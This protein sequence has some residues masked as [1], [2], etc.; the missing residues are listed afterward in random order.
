MVQSNPFG[1]AGGLAAILVLTAATA[2]CGG[3]KTDAGSGSARVTAACVG[4][5]AVARDSDGEELCWGSAKSDVVAGEEASI[6]VA[7]LDDVSSRLTILS[8]V[9]SQSMVAPG[10]SASVAVVASDADGGGP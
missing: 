3:A 2:G 8:L 6:S 10:A 1:R 5:A 9:A 4:R 7:L